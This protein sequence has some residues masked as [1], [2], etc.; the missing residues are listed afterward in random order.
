MN[1]TERSPQISQEDF[2]MLGVN[3]DRSAELS[4]ACDSNNAWILLHRVAP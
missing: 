1:T 4:R 2:V 3:S